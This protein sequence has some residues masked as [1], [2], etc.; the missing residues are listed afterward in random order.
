MES[1]DINKHVFKANE[2]GE[3]YLLFITV[4][5]ALL[6]GL[7]AYLIISSHPAFSS[8]QQIGVTALVICVISAIVLTLISAWKAYSY[9]LGTIVEIDPL[10]RHFTYT[11][12]RRTIEF[13]GGDVQE[14]YSDIGLKIGFGKLSRLT[15]HD[16]VFVLKSGQVLYLHAWLWDGDYSWLHAG[17]S[18]EHNIKFYLDAHCGQLDLPQCKTAEKTLCGHGTDTDGF[19]HDGRAVF[20][21]DRNSRAQYQRLFQYDVRSQQRGR[22]RY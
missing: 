15:E 22:S 19:D 2:R 16:S 12:N 17:G 20:L 3:R 11:H 9:A 4:F 8:L 10:S 5:C 13:S 21:P 6:V 1:L 14:W 7:L 18:W